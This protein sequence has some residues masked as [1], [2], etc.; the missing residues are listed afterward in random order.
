MSR[1][2]SW[3]F[4]ETWKELGIDDVAPGLT[5]AEKK[6]TVADLL[7][8]RSSVYHPALG[9]VATMKQ[10]RPRPGSHPPGTFWYYNNRDFNALGTI[11]EQETGTRI[12]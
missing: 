10:V 3:T 7:A 2:A 5:P 11:F 8:S 1:R 6:A 12:F 4:R 9:E